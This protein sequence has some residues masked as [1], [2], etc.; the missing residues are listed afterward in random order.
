[1]IQKHIGI[2]HDIYHTM[3]HSFNVPKRP[4]TEART[5]SLAASGEAILKASFNLHQ[6]WIY[7]LVPYEPHRPYIP[8]KLTVNI[9][10][11]MKTHQRQ[12]PLHFNLTST[13]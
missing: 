4:W 1:M 8:Y 5:G 11:I 7:I 9:I 6:I 2:V 3:F 13:H 12:Y 10:E